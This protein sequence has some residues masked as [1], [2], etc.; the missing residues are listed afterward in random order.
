MSR[1]ATDASFL[2]EFCGSRMAIVVVLLAQLLAIA[3]T[4]STPAATVSAF[5]RLALYSVM[6]LWVSL[7]CL[8]ALCLLRRRVQT[9]RSEER[10]VG[11]ECRL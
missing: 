9:L 10:R 7:F 8:G 6:S 3:L 1:K 2:P 11:K 4:L 5:N